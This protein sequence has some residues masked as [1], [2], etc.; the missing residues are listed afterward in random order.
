[1]HYNKFKNSDLSNVDFRGSD[2]FSSNFTGSNLDGANF[3][4]IYPYS[5][6]FTNAIFTENDENYSSLINLLRNNNK[7]II[8]CQINFQA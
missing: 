7:G 6:D 8:N 2:L 5:V 4:G 1:M 3:L